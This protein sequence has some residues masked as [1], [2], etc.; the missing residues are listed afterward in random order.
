MIRAE[1][2]FEGLRDARERA[3]FGESVFAQVS[4]TP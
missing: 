4:T 3:G 2:R 1:V